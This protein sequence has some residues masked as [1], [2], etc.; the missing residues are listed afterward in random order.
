MRARRHA[1]LNTDRE[2]GLARNFCHIS[3]YEVRTLR[4]GIRSLFRKRTINS[5][6]IVIKVCV[7]SS[8]LTAVRIARVVASPC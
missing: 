6:I 8:K 3:R 1:S 2:K 7:R 4:K 5:I